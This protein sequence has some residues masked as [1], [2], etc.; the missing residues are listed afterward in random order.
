MA[1]ELE[2]ETIVIEDDRPIPVF[3]I[4]ASGIGAIAGYILAGGGQ[5]IMFQPQ[6]ANNVAP[7]NNQEG[8]ITL[9]HILGAML[10]TGAGF[11][12]GSAMDRKKKK[13]T[14]IHSRE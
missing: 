7:P 14:V 11:A 9:Q 3:T 12:I 6:Q 1:K 8:G 10:G 13:R 2:T 5:T 4:L